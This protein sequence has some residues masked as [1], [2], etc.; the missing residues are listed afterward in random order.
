VLECRYS[1]GS[2][3]AD[4]LASARSQF[5]AMTAENARRMLAFW[6]VRSTAPARVN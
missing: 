3:G 4:E 1:T 5:A 2:V 6:Q